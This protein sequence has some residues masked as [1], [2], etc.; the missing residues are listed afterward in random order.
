MLSHPV[1]SNVACMGSALELPGVRATSPVSS[2]DSV[3]GAAKTGNKQRRSTEKWRARYWTS[4]LNRRIL[5]VAIEWK[6]SLDVQCCDLDTYSF[7]VLANAS[8]IF[9]FPPELTESIPRCAFSHRQCTLMSHQ[10]AVGDVCGHEKG[11]GHR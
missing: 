6:R 9:I 7:P 4:I 10:G 2:E 11:G 8:Y 5:F 3:I 1:M